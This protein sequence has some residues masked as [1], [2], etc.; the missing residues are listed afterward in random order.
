MSFTVAGRA[1]DKKRIVCLPGAFEDGFC[2]RVRELIE[3]TYDKSFESVTRIKI[4]ALVYVKRLQIKRSV[5]RRRCLPQLSFR[6]H[7]GRGAVY[8]VLNRS[9][10]AVQG[11]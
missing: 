5:F 8:C 2:G 1:V 9:N 4:I 6:G 11:A 7:W 3:G 10:R